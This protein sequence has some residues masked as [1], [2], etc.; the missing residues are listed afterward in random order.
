M[1]AE[2]GALYAGTFESQ[3][4]ATTGLACL[5]LH[6]YIKGLRLPLPEVGHWYSLDFGGG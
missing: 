4:P 6:R 1:V 3:T 5:F 2:S